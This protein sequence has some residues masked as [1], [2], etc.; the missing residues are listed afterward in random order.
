MPQFL[1]LYNADDR[2]AHLTELGDQGVNHGEHLEQCLAE[3]TGSVKGSVNYPSGAS[4]RSKDHLSQR[5]SPPPSPHQGL[6]APGGTLS[7]CL[8]V[9]AWPLGNE[10]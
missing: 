2:R 5:D 3:G 9:S 4:H 10:I 6:R 7:C 8:E 1:H